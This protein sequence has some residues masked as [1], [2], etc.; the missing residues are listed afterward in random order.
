MKKKLAHASS[1]PP[2][3]ENGLFLSGEAVLK[4]GTCMTQQGFET[5]TSRH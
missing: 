4:S 2:R 5:T 1:L 3:I